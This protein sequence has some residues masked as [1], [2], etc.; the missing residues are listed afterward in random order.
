MKP[1]QGAVDRIKGFGG[2]INAYMHRRRNKQKSRV[3][4]HW[5]DGTT[6]KTDP[7]LQQA[8]RLLE[9]VEQ[10]IKVSKDL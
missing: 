2:E 4:F 3:L 1:K 9:K 8:Q 6:T 5:K 10:L 7:E